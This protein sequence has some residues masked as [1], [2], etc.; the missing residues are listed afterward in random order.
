MGMGIIV[1]CAWIAGA[2]T[3]ARVDDAEKEE[4]KA[5]ELKPV[6]FCA[7]E[8]EDGYQWRKDPQGGMV[9]S[10]LLLFKDHVLRLSLSL[11]PEEYETTFTHMHNIFGGCLYSIHRPNG[12][13]LVMRRNGADVLT[14][15]GNERV[16]DFLVKGEDIY[17]LTDDNGTLKMRINETLVLSAQKAELLDEMYLDMGEVCFSYRSAAGSTG[18]VQAYRYF[19]AVEGHH[20]LIRPFSNVREI[21]A[22]RRHKG[23]INILQEDAD[24]DGIVW[25]Y[26]DASVILTNNPKF[27]ECSFMVFGDTILAHAELYEPRLGME[28][29]T[30]WFDNIWYMNPEIVKQQIFFDI[31]A[32][33]RDSP[34]PWF[35]TR[36]TEPTLYFIQKGRDFRS[37]GSSYTMVSNHAF[38]GDGTRVYAGML[39]MYDSRPVIF[40]GETFSEKN[41]NGYFTHLSLP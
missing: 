6:Y 25:D 27:R 36:V 40:N 35:I 3:A 9:P 10:R 5:P 11:P 4:D 14:I 15:D 39:T 22:I 17:I 24:M 2:C 29:I 37:I 19:L 20:S 18:S 16:L 41:F 28:M 21:L 23:A 31:Y 33:C 30:S 26:E 32:L 7:V 34:V 12:G 8:Y 13:R 38:C 1:L